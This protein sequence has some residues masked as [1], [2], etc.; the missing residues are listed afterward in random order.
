MT[1]DEWDAMRIVGIALLVA[2]AVFVALMAIP[3]KQ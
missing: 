3:W 2:A 1:R